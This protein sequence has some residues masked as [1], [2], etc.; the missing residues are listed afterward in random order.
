MVIH[1]HWMIWTMTNRNLHIHIKKTYIYS[2]F[3]S[4]S[5]FSSQPFPSQRSTC[6]DLFP[7]F[8]EPS[9]TRHLRPLRWK[10]PEA[11]TLSKRR[12]ADVRNRRCFFG[13]E[14][15]TMESLEIL[16]FGHYKHDKN[17]FKNS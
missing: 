3:P 16:T 14:K 5:Q 1:D 15:T 2:D 6:L 11:E 13:Y 17:P 4:F 9:I 7:T 10:A 12:K 8:P